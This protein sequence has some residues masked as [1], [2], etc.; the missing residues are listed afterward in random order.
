MRIKHKNSEPVEEIMGVT[1]SIEK[2]ERTE[3]EIVKPM[4]M[5]KIIGC[6]SKRTTRC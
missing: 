1:Q 2:E 6:E 3:Q 5:E 4:R